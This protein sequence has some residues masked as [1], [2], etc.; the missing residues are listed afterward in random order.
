MTA[1]G[2]QTRLYIGGEWAEPSD[3]RSVDVVNPTTEE[4]I[5]R[6]RLAGPPDVDRAVTAARAAV[7]AGPWASSTPSERAAIMIRAG[8]LIGERAERFAQTIT[9]EV[10]SPLAIASWQPV[11]AKLY[12]DWHAAQ[13]G[14]Y[15]WEEEREGI[16]GPMLVRRRPVGV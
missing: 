4:S 10:G 16:R 6:V 8:E 9:L 5:A 2:E 1:I 13:A 11:A 14:T 3:G 12:L 7:D 15:P